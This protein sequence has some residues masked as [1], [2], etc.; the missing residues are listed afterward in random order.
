MLSVS[1]RNGD[2][3][4]P[5]GHWNIRSLNSIR[6]VSAWHRR[7]GPSPKGIDFVS[8]EN[9]P[10][11][12]FSI[13]TLGKPM[14]GPDSLHLDL[15]GKF[16]NQ[17]ETVYGGLQTGL[18]NKP[19]GY[20]WR[21]QQLEALKRL[22]VENDEALSKA[23]WKDLR[24]SS[25]E[26]QATEQGI[27]LGEIQDTMKHLKKWMRPR[28]VST[29]LYNQPGRSQIVH[30]PYGLALIIG[31]WN[32][33][34]NLTLA[35]LVG[36]I[37]GGNAAIIKPSELS[38]HTAGLLATLIPKYLDPELFAVV[39]GAVPETDAL[40]ELKF[41]TIF[42]TG[43]SAV[44]KIIMTKAAKHLTPVTLELGGKSP[45]IV[46]KDADLV[47]TARRLAWGK[48][49]NAGQTCVAPDYIICESGV[50]NDLIKEMKKALVDFYG[51]DAFASPDYCRIINQKNFDRLLLLSEGHQILYGGAFDREQLYISPTILEASPNSEIMQ[52]EIFGPLLPIFE[53]SEL[54]KMIEFI[55]LR[56]KPLAL[57]LFTKNGKT[58]DQVAKCTSSG[59]LCVNDVVMH[60]PM[61]ELPFGGVGASGMGHYHGE[62]SF[63]T[64]THAKGIL[65]K[66]FWLDVPVRY[67]PYT[68]QKAKWLR[69]LL[70]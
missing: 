62:F 26:C 4:S 38:A 58:I 49:M 30:D 22:L 67:A 37:A 27:V 60:L 15:V 10:P 25:F 28:K 64:F 20:A 8:T 68:K 32:Y 50:K 66:S 52:Q 11:V 53:M 36:A 21:M 23:M 47:V 17:I 39:E 5:F 3:K 9:F 55:N 46:M 61:A 40:L 51:M 24:K 31:A 35:P 7:G 65:K 34:V 59:A 29:P 57:Y 63:K 33:P 56:P 16:Q 45:A 44:G 48:F 41:D 42:F 12:C 43:S 69:W 13:L 1:F 2:L 54:P 70:S 19:R 18:L 6:P 14:S